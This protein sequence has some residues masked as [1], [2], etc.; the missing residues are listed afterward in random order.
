MGRTNADNPHVRSSVAD[1][2]MVSIPPDA[3]VGG[4]STHALRLTSTDPFHYED[5]PLVEFMYLVGL[6]TRVQV[7]LTV[8][9]SGLCCCVCVTSFKR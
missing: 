7:R 5:V 6:F 3:A 8:G 2:Q 9:D 4:L 1:L